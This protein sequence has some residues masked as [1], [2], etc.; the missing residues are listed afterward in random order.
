VVFDSWR[1]RYTDSPRAI[2][3]ELVRRDV[4]FDAVW[5]LAEGQPGPDGADTVLP[6]SRD[7]VSAMQRAR[8]VVLNDLLP[9]WYLKPPWA[10]VTQTWHGTPLKRIGLDVVDPSYP[11]ARRYAW[12]LRRNSR[13]W[14]H[15]V[16][17]NPFSTPIFRRAFRYRGSVLEVGYPRND[18]LL[19]AAAP[20][21]LKVPSATATV[22]FAPT[23]RDSG[24][25]RDELAAEVRELAASLGPERLVLLRLHKH[26]ADALAGVDLPGNVHDVSSHGHINDVLAVADALITDYSSV[27]FDFAVTGR[28]I[29]LFVPDL[30]RYRDVERGFYFDPVAEGPGPVER[31]I[32]EVAASVDS[33]LAGHGDLPRY[34][35]FKERFVPL[36]DGRAAARVVEAVFGS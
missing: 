17:Q 23:W 16:S 26:E 22:A 20:V 4:T 5:V 10:T 14:D 1:G 32:S 25:R 15:V 29:V 6:H 33:L 12:H 31:T 28:P 36:D 18:S 3:E 11:N 21:G 13:L 7:H 19:D 35:A 24:D 30:E 34:A 8:H 27:M 9:L 2:Y